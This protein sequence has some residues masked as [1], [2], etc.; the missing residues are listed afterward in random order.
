MEKGKVVKR[1]PSVE[2][3]DYYLSSGFA[4]T[5]E[6]YWEDDEVPANAAPFKPVALRIRNHED[7]VINTVRSIE[8][9]TIEFEYELTEAITGL[10]IGFYLLSSRG[11]FVFTSF[12]TDEPRVYDKFTVREAG[13]YISRCEIPA[14]TFNEGR[15]VVGVNASTYRIRRYFQ[16]ER[17]ITFNVDPAGAPGMQWPEQRQGPI[18]PRLNWEIEKR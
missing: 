4:E 14:D 10:R 15:F 11:E 13:K 18:R 17:A 6:R 8:K 9:M 2:A 12:D 16:D 5:G 7:M 3:V 1:A